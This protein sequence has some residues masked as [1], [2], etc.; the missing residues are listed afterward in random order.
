MIDRP[1]EFTAFFSQLQYVVGWP[2]VWMKRLDQ[3]HP[4]H[5]HPILPC[6]TPLHSTSPHSQIPHGHCLLC[7]PL[8]SLHLPICLLIIGTVAMVYHVFVVQALVDVL[9][10]T[11]REHMLPDIVN[12][13]GPTV[14]ET[15]AWV[16]DSIFL[17][18]QGPQKGS[19]M[20]A[21]LHH[22]IRKNLIG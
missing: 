10:D 17:H 1:L 20:L 6:L 11:P 7:L 18:T 8:G 3:S 22:C 21:G 15:L 16:G 4:A 19:E 13:I 5:P 12:C 2:H 14:D 9:I